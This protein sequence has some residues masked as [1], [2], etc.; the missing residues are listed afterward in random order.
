MGAD[1]PANGKN[2]EGTAQ[3]AQ[4]QPY[5]AAVAPDGRADCETGQRGWLERNAG[6]LDSKYRVNLNPRTPGAQGPT[7]TGQPRV[8]A[9]RPSRPSRRRAT[10]RASA[11]PRRGAMKRRAR[12]ISSFSNAR[13]ALVTL[14]VLIPLVFLG[15]TKTIPFKPSYEISAVFESSNNLKKGSPVRIAGVEVGKV[16]KRRRPWPRGARRSR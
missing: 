9:G 13:I 2:A 3:Y 5:G 10:T 4:D 12:K 1:E 15:F 11:R 6:G 7:F 16:T 8:P 14:A